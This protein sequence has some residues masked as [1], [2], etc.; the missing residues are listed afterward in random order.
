MEISFQNPADN[1]SRPPA[2]PTINQPAIFPT[3]PLIHTNPTFLWRPFLTGRRKA[4]ASKANCSRIRPAHA[5]GKRSS[6]KGNEGKKERPVAVVRKTLKE[7]SSGGV[8]PVRLHF[9]QGDA[10]KVRRRR[11]KKKKGI[12]S[13]TICNQVVCNKDCFASGSCAY[14]IW[15]FSP[16]ALY[17][18]VSA[19]KRK[20][21]MHSAPEFSSQSLQLQTA[22]TPMLPSQKS[23]PCKK[24]L[25]SYQNETLPQPETQA[26]SATLPY[27][28][29][30]PHLLICV[31]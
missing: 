5:T 10:F 19:F 1:T 21:T 12:Q 30:T 29:I 9:E 17:M 18:W 26:K 22:A 2:I 20:N 3:E 31:Y 8:L 14:R 13:F 4:A 6:N 23:P 24:S 16:S 28:P 15:N 11:G 27:Y 25:T 7:K